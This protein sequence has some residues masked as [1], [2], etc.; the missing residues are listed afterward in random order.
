LLEQWVHV[1]WE[2]LQWLLDSEFGEELLIV[3]AVAVAN[4]MAT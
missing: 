1:M 3:A 4:V 2:M